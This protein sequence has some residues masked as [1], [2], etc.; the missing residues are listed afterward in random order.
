NLISMTIEIKE[1]E[2]PAYSELWFVGGFTGW[3]FQPMTR[4]AGNPFI[5]HYN[6]VLS[7]GGGSDEFKIATVPDFDPSVVFLR[8]ET[9][10]QGAGTEL[11]VVSWSESSN[12]EDFKWRID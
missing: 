9:N 3:S 10:S 7:S 6:G 5:F 1:M 4:N 11:P 12:S 2:G 8:P